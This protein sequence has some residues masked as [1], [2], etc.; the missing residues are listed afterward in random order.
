MEASRFWK[1][2]L[3]IQ[4]F[5]KQNIPMQLAHTARADQEEQ[6]NCEVRPISACIR[7]VIPSMQEIILYEVCG[8]YIY[9]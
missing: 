3:E 7:G 4:P 1:D 5:P 8:K 6:P 9:F 2:E